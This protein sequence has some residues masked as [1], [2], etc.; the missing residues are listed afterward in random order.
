M[1]LLAQLHVLLPRDRHS[2]SVDVRQL[3]PFLRHNLATVRTA[4]V[5]LFTSLIGG[6]PEIG[7]TWKHCPYLLTSPI[8][9]KGQ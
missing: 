8:W 1:E 3:W 4:A 5:D 9:C 2:S 7:K 6:T